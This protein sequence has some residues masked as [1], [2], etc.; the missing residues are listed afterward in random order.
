MALGACGM[1][2]VK[3]PVGL[4]AAVGNGKGGTVG[5]TRSLGNGGTAGT[6]GMAAVGTAGTAGGT[7][8]MTVDT[9]TTF[10]VLSTISWTTTVAMLDC[11]DACACACAIRR[12]NWRWPSPM[13]TR[14]RCSR[15][16]N[17]SLM[18]AGRGSSFL[19]CSCAG[20]FGDECWVRWRMRRSNRAKRDGPGAASMR[21]WEAGRY[22]GA[23]G[24]LRGEVANPRSALCM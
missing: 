24:S 7:G 11:G 10:P 9:A 5:T 17:G 1:P 18:L 3:V 15:A 4:A 20:S 12:W 21:V 13:T 19:A 16:S 2:K 14:P 22:R 23:G 8:G 6:A